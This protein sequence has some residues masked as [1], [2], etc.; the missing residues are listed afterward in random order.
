MDLGGS[1]PISV[2]L[3]FV[4]ARR[5]LDNE[6]RKIKE[7]KTAVVNAR[8]TLSMNLLLSLNYLET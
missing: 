5:S 2:R 3:G 7:M 6:I 8:I 4:W 1:P